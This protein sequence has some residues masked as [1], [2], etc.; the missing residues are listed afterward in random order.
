MKSVFKPGRGTITLKQR[1]AL[2]AR[3]NKLRRLTASKR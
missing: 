2:R 3:V 1:A